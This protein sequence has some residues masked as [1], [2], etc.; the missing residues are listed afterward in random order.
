[1]LALYKTFISLPRENEDT[2]RGGGSGVSGGDCCGGGGGGDDSG[3]GTVG[4]VL[5]SWSENV[6]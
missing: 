3:R 2:V 4:I 5:E 1:M 6:I